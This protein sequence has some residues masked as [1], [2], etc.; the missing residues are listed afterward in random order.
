MTDNDDNTLTTEITS[1]LGEFFGEDDQS[2]TYEGPNNASVPHEYSFAHLKALVLSIEWE[3]TDKGEFPG[4]K[5]AFKQQNL[6]R[7]L[8]V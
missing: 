4:S 3:I 1:R 8:I 6:K 5:I 2:N 7:S